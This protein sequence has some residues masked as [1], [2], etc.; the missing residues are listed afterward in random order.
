VPISHYV[1][2][3]YN[4][5]NALRDALTR[6][7]A[8]SAEAAVDGLEGLTVSTPTGPVSIG[9]VD[10]HVTLPMFLAKSEG[11]GLVT[12]QD[13]GRIAPEAGCG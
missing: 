5:M 3:H 7:D 1:M 2:T 12:V 9:G 10:H 8:V 6:K 13:L 11:A 4:A